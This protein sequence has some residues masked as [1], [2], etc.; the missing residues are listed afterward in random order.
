MD[1][2]LLVSAALLLT[3]S[4]PG[5]APASAQDPDTV[6]AKPDTVRVDIP[7]LAT[8]TVVPQDGTAG[9][10][11]PP[12]PVV[13]L[14]PPLPDAV[15]PGFERGVWTWDRADLLS[16]RALVL[17][18]LLAQVP[19]VVPLRG[20][21]Y[22]APRTVSAFG[23]AG[24]RIRVIRDGVEVIPLG[25][26][27]DFSRISLAG[28]ERVRVER[29]PGELRVE[30]TGLRVDD[31]RPYSRV[32]AG[33]GDLDT[34]FFRG[35][36][37]HPN[38]FGG[39]AAVS[40]DRIDTRGR[41][42]R[43]PASATGGWIRYQRAW[44]ERGLAAEV[45]RTTT[46]LD[47]EAGGFTPEVTRTDWVLRGRSRLARDWTAHA[48]ASRTQWEG[49]TEG[50]EADSILFDG[51]RDQ[52]GAGVRR[53]G[54]LLAGAADVRFLRGE[55]LPDW[56]ADAE[57]RL[58]LPA[59]G[60]AAASAAWEG[61]KGEGALRLRLRGWTEVRAGLSAFASIESGEAGVPFVR[62]TFP[63]PRAEDG[64][65]E[66]DGDEGGEEGEDAGPATPT[67][68][69]LSD[70]SALRAGLRLGWRGV[71]LEGAWIRLD[72]EPL[73]SLGLPMDSADL[74]LPGGTATGLEVQG[75]VPLLLLDSLRLEGWW[76]G[77]DEGLRYL[78][79]HNY[80]ARISF[81]DVYLPTENFELW[82]VV[83]VRGR[84]PMEV[85]VPAEA[86][87][88]FRAGPGGG[89]LVPFDQSWYARIQVRVVTVHAFVQWE[90]F[91]IRRNRQ[92]FPDRLLPKTRAMYG[93]RWT[94][95]N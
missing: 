69:V 67:G 26:A 88:A 53:E 87:P 64:E 28:V 6:P 86:A 27:P 7:P 34:N 14:L 35:T 50:G 9:D 74:G 3:P 44:G 85:A 47:F 80:D 33:T 19:G 76:Q 11:V 82:A 36:F 77:W 70:R 8:D 5:T 48:F 90:N 40:L 66:Q 29:H 23:G 78:P 54:P 60:G 73:V 25:G 1:R 24:G 94:L 45:H 49:K 68:P 46:D 10:T 55:G 13:T 41:D 12:E 57:V 2:V 32:E 62:S 89:A 39:G 84:S 83:G 22:G 20:G 65:E 61:W 37:S 95:W 58:A 17:E 81:H 93:V 43:E 18:E 31:P 30:L 75:R 59:L 15:E 92:D 51:D 63:A 52:F 21:D 91:T 56:T 16:T 79:R 71:E 72:A 38:A 4:L 42:R